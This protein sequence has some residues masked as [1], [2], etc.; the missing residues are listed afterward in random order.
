MRR[1]LFISALLHVAVIAI[2]YFGLP[3]LLR[4]DPIL[5]AP[6]VLEVVMALPEQAKPPPPKPVSKPVPKEMPRVEDTP[7]PSPPKPPPAIPEP[8]PMPFVEAPPEVEPP[9]KAAPKPKP[10]PVAAP[11]P[12]PA[13]KVQ[14]ALLAPVPKRRPKR[15]PKPP[16]DG[17]QSL[18]KN[19]ASPKPSARKRAA[20]PAKQATTPDPVQS[21]IQ[22]RAVEAELTR[23]VRQQ[24]IPCW[25]IPAGA[26]DV[27]D[28]K[29]GMRIRL[30]RDGSLIGRP[31]LIKS[32]RDDPFY[33]AVAE[34]ARRALQNP[35]CQPLNLPRQQYEIWK[36]IT[37]NFDPSEALGP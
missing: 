5:S 23:L 29:I 3:T 26:K 14:T 11:K 1:A 31:E 27:R 19:L 24:I 30:N 12:K 2:G 32:A 21:A 9:P 20:A 36:S 35:Q 13:P 18:L 28:M 34:S 37:F 10:K 25:S 22:R 15:K 17:F 4:P 6:V 16:T 8:P 33:R 7:P